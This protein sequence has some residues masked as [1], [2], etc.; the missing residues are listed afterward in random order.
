MLLLFAAAS[1]AAPPF[2]N[3]PDAGKTVLAAQQGSQQ[4]AATVVAPPTRTALAATTDPLAE[5]SAYQTAH[6]KNYPYPTSNQ[7]WL[8]TLTGAMWWRCAPQI[9][10][11]PRP[12][13][14]N[15]SATS[16]PSG[17]RSRGTG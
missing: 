2:V 5:L 11:R 17:T 16:P 7:A 14:A 8:A 13:R 4:A 15:Y 3:P 12:P 6:L 10:P 9:V 1:L